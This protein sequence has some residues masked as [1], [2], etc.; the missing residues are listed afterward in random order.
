MASE[1]HRS[2]ESSTT[3]LT[4]CVKGRTILKGLCYDVITVSNGTV[5]AN[6]VMTLLC[7]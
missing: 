5:C 4:V 7:V 6:G 1:L 3:S 2:E